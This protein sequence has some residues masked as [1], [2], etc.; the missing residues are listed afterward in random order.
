MI[1]NMKKLVFILTALLLTACSAPKVQTFE[2]YFTDAGIT[3][4]DELIIQDG[5]TGY[6]KTTDDPQHIDAFL[7][8]LNPIEVIPDD[9]QEARNGWRYGITL[10]QG[11]KRYLFTLN[12]IEDMYYHT[13]PDLHPFV[14]VFYN[15]LDVEEK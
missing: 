5:S 8:E 12:S 15:N 11:E 6:T 7:S 13:E 4:V 10:V 1:G 2:K 9:N 3:E 14:D